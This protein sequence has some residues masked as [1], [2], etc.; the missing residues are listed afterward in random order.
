MR[1]ELAERYLVLGVEAWNL[2]DEEGLLPVNPLTIRDHLLSDFMR[3]EKVADAADEL[4]AEVAL[5]PLRR[6]MSNYSP[7]G[8][9]NRSTSQK[10]TGSGKPRRRSK[11][12]STSTSQTGVTVAISA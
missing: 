6:L 12:S 11:P 3:S 9:I 1:A 8:P 2:S 5:L 4:Y 7:G 10:R